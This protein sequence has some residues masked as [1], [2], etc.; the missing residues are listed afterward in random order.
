[1]SSVP[2]RSQVIVMGMSRSG[3]SLTTSI[4]AEL[5]GGG[6][7][8]TWRGSG[9]ALPAGAAN[10]LGYFERQDVVDLNYRLLN[11]CNASTWYTFPADHAHRPLALDASSCRPAALR[12]R[13]AL[14]DT[15][16]YITSD[17]QH[18]APW[19]LKDV[20][21]ARTLPL[22]APLL[23]RPLCI[24]P[25]R[26]P[27]EVAASSSVPSDRVAVWTNY[28][29]AA[30]SSARAVGCPALLV[31]YERWL[32]ADSARAQLAE[33]NTFLACSGVRELRATPPY[34]ALA[35]LVRS[36][37]DARKGRQRP[38]GTPRELGPIADCLWNELRSGR[39][40]LWPW[41]STTRRFDRLPWSKPGPASPCSAGGVAGDDGARGTAGSRS[42]RGRRAPQLIG[43]TH[44]RK[45]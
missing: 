18:H 37:S 23:D 16:R 5:L 25:Y 21:F 28:M 45:S 26:H 20:R 19:V 13:L 35:R 38:H 17:M 11:V 3:T 10:P 29:L 36:P 34:E 22:W 42:S 14:M 32:S 44:T 9:K 39:A 33:L 1:M 24:I 40:L 41:N 2:S 4:V 43:S 27:A 7:V 31:S 6:R 12:H 8:A 15:A 30:L